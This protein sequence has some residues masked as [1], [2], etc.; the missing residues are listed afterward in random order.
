MRVP[1]AGPSMTSTTSPS[2][3]G[4][5]A[6]TGG[7]TT[8]ITVAPASTWSPW[9]TGSAR[10]LLPVDER[11]VGR[12]EVLDE[13]PL[14]V[15]RHAG[16][17]SRELRVLPEGAGSRLPPSE[18]EPFVPDRDARAGRR[19]FEDLERGS[20][21]GGGGAP[22]QGRR[23]GADHGG[24]RQR[25]VLGVLDLY[26]LPD[27]RRGRRRL[28]SGCGLGR[29]LGRSRRGR[30]GPRGPRR[31][32]DRDQATTDPAAATPA[33]VSIRT[34]KPSTK[35]SGRP[36]PRQGRRHQPRSRSRPSGPGP[37]EPP[38]CRVELI[39]AAPIPACWNGTA[40]RAA[41][42]S[43]GQHRGEA[44]PPDHHRRQ[45]RPEVGVE[46]EALEQEERDGQERHAHG[47][48]RPGA[49]LA[50]QLADRGPKTHDH[51][52][53]REL[54]EARSRWRRSP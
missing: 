17:A 51:R 44:D 21:L 19:A 12:A 36:L 28:G 9:R 31:P 7:A 1:E 30:G 11:A 25:P 50:D 4:A 26:L 42:V 52:H 33:P 15:A 24:R 14:V 35:A 40:D 53:H 54:R 5:A 47:E 16:V 2:G 27:G 41:A 34:P 37:S 18:H 22:G 23:Q 10:D 32:R 29:R 46:V 6:D 20:A 38:T 13:Q 8:R 43:G 3:E 39:T 49:D 45:E 48:H